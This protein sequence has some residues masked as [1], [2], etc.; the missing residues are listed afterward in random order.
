[1]NF[2]TPLNRSIQSNFRLETFFEGN[3][4]AEGLFEDRFGTIR[5][6][7]NVA[8]QGSFNEN[9]LTTFESKEAALSLIFSSSLNKIRSNKKYAFNLN[10]GVVKIST[11]HSFKGYESPTVFLIV[12]DRDSPELVYVGITRAKINLVVFVEPDGRYE[13]FF[14]SRLEAPIEDTKPFSGGT[15]TLSS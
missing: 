5:K 6:R 9:T 8:I 1:M 11:I 2:L 13:A 3:S 4:S 10:S 15:G 7:F 12:N 14:K